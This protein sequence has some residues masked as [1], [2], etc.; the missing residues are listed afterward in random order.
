MH[1]TLI[2]LF[3]GLLLGLAWAMDGFAGLVLTAALGIIGFV[4]GKV[5]AGEVDLNQYFGGSNRSPR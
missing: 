3:C 2:G 4:V 5:I 1:P